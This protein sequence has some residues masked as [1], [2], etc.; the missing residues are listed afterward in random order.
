M[1]VILT[2]AATAALVFA[3]PVRADDKADL[4]KIIDKAIKAHGGAD[5][6]GQAKAS[7][8]KMK[9]KVY[10]MV[11]DGIEF[12]AELK[13]QE[14]DKSRMDISGE[15][16]GAKFEFVHVVN[17][18]KGWKKMMGNTED[19]DKDE[20]EEQKEQ[21]YADRVTRLVGLKEKGLEFATLG[22]KKIGERAAIG[23]SVSSKGHRPISMYFDKE[24]G[25]LLAT[26]RR[27]K[28]NSQELSQ[29]T[30]YRDYKDVDGVKQPHKLT[31]NRE[32]KKY[33]EAEITEYKRVDKLDDGTFDKP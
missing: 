18:D 23:I 3:A 24:T 8:A 21:R 22:D 15:F 20:I 29:E 4:Q 17:G 1:R 26:E 14:P 25:M 30:I 33:L 31:I 7:T 28:E 2:V 27:V 11:D 12:T 6:V 10:G 5:K 19:M 13:T 16:M 32:G 9:G